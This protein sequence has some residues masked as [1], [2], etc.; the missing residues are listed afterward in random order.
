MRASVWGWEYGSEILSL[1]VR[2]DNAPKTEVS[3]RVIRKWTFVK[4]ERAVDARNRTCVYN[5]RIYPAH[6]GIQATYS[7]LWKARY[8]LTRRASQAQRGT[9]C[10]ARFVVI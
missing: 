10:L 8:K 9:H 1:E 2:R 7:E 4:I 3:T 5:G 6:D